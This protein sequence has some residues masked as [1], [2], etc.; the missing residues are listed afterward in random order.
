MLTWLITCILPLFLFQLVGHSSKEVFGK[1]ASNT[2]LCMTLL[3]GQRYLTL[4][5][6]HCVN[7]HSSY[8]MLLC[9]VI[10]FLML[11]FKIIL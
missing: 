3:L 9:D 10:G 8:F 5:N 7:V 11:R 1:H 6:V 4:A 2:A